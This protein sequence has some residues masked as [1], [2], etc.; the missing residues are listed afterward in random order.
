MTDPVSRRDAFAGLAVITALVGSETAEASPKPT[1]GDGATGFSQADGYAPGTIGAKLKQTVSVKDPPFNAVGDG[2]ADDTRSF[3][4]ALAASQTVRVPHGSY[5]LTERLAL[6]EGNALVGDGSDSSV[7]VFVGSGDGIV[8]DRSFRRLHLTGLTLRCTNPRGGRAL[9]L[10]T[11]SRGYIADLQITAAPSGRWAY[12]VWAENWQTSNFYAIRILQSCTIGVHLEFAC[13]ANQWYGLEIIGS[14]GPGTIDRALE[15]TS[16][17][18][19]SCEVVSFEEFFHGGTFQ[20]YFRK[21]A[22]HAAGVSP[23][24]TGMHIENTNPEPSDGADVWL[25]GDSAS[26]IVN[27]KFAHFQGGSF[28]TT[29]IVRNLSIVHSEVGEVVLGAETLETSLLGVRYTNLRDQGRATT[30]LGCSGGTGQGVLA[31]IN[32]SGGLSV[33]AD[34][35]MV[36]QLDAGGLLLAGSAGRSPVR[37]S[38]NTTSRAAFSSKPLGYLVATVGGREVRIP[39][40]PA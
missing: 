30:V 38:A 36:A 37:L 8:V 13:N 3:I 32:G 12:G 35:N 29:G 15:M 34:G 10:S 20:G 18:G 22:I 5:R 14:S 2:R 4:A 1:A 31:V 28:G 39:Y 7:L 17:S 24:M 25:D 19:S 16:R 23:L 6:G 9:A 33:R 26:A 40:Y 11:G 21:S 27:P